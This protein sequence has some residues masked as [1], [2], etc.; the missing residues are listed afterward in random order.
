MMPVI[1]FLLICGEFG[2]L[3]G[4]NG[5]NH[6]HLASPKVGISGG[7]YSFSEVIGSM[8]TFCGNKSSL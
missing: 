3:L 8:Y 7:I 4:S 2:S 1:S 5:G 6:P